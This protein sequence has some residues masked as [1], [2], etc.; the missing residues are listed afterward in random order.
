MLVEHGVDDVDERLVAVED[1]VAPGE[2]IALEPALA[3]VLAE[4]L[5]HPPVRRQ[6]V[7]AVTALGD[8]DAV[9]RLENP[10]EPIGG[11]LVGAEHAEV[12]RRLVCPHDVAQPGAE[13]PRRLAR[14]RRRPLHAHGVA[15]VVRQL[16]VAQQKAAVRVRVGAHPALATR[17]QR[18]QLLAEAARLVEQLVGAV[19]A[20]PV[21]ELA[22]VLR[23]LEQLCQ[24]D[25]M[26]AERPLGRLTVDLLR[27][28]P[29]LRRAQHDHWPCGT[30]HFAA[31]G[32]LLYAR[33]LVK[34]GVE[35]RGEGLV[36]GLRLF[37]LHEPRRMPIALEQRAELAFRNAS[38]DGGVRDLVA[39]QMENR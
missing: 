39:V 28:G 15:P 20:Q 10:A 27:T 19:R 24:R 22:E 12:A 25:L 37:A 8:P 26:R 1:P 17:A 36:H 13:H 38:E 16:Q 7:V 30:G 23:I 6:M 33:D 3:E 31:S 4:D 11:G 21:L 29:A 14:G 2:Q 5:H 34:R 32:L 9:G 18:A 35:R